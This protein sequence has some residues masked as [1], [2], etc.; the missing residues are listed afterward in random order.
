[1]NIPT[2]EHWQMAARHGSQFLCN[3]TGYNLVQE[4]KQNMEKFN[5]DPQQA[6]FLLIDFQSNLAVAM[7]KD[8][9]AGC[10]RNAG[11]VIASCNI[12]RSGPGRSSTARGWGPLLSA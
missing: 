2:A 3:I 12:L 4:A 7:K 6:L 9:Y 8:V 10:E 5:I 1:V 11:L